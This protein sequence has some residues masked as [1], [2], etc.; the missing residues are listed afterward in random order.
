[1]DLPRFRESELI[2]DGGKDFDNREGSFTFRGEFGVGN[3]AFEIS[4]FEPDLVSFGKGGESSVVT[5]GHYLVSELVCSEGFV[6]SGN[7][8]L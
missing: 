5:R 8:G 2:G 3:G 4:G 1:M 6:S 7:E